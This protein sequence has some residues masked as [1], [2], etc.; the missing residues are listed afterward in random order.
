MQPNGLFHPVPEPSLR[1]ISGILQARIERLFVPRANAQRIIDLLEEHRTSQLQPVLR[2]F[3][4]QDK[5]YRGPEVVAMDNLIDFLTEIF[6]GK[7]V[8]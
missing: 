5:S 6:F 4:G 1:H 2:Q 8:Q 3:D 7:N